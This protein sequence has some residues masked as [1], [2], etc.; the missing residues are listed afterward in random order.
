MVY[1]GIFFYYKSGVIFW[2]LFQRKRCL[3]ISTKY[4]DWAKSWA[5]F[6][7][8]HLVTPRKIWQTLGQSHDSELQ[9]QRCKKFTT[10]RVA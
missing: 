10:S 9:R 2:L 3:S 5:I 8:N 4:M 6:S 1:L 7:H